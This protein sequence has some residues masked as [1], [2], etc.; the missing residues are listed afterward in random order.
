MG[1]VIG[2]WAQDGQ[3]HMDSHCCGHHHN[4]FVSDSW[5]S[6]INEIVFN[7]SFECQ[8]VIDAIE[9]SGK[10][11]SMAPYLNIIAKVKTT[12]YQICTPS[13]VEYKFVL[14]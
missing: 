6:L 1:I 14:L 3:L 2:H 13:H 4:V 11:N 8:T 7:F 5:E 9:D 12:G 10:E